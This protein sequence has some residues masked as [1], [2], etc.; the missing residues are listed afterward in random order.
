V[1][2]AAERLVLGVAA[3]AQGVVLER[4][5]LG[6]RDEFPLLVSLDSR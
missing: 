2:A 4:G 1:H 5:S 3:P 6:A